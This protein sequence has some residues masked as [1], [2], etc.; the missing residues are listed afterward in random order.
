[1]IRDSQRG[2]KREERKDRKQEKKKKHKCSNADKF[3]SFK[4][5]RETDKD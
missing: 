5:T 2:D 1:M 3:G 4:F